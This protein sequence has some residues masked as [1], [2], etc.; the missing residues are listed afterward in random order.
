MGTNIFPIKNES[1][2]S[3]VRAA[4][5]RGVR[6]KRTKSENGGCWKVK[7]VRAKSCLVGLHTGKEK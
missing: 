6:V 7:C 5:S 3:E 4:R 1:P 2:D